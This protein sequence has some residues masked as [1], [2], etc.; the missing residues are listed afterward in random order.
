MFKCFNPCRAQFNYFSLQRKGYICIILIF[1]LHRL[2]LEHIL[3]STPINSLFNVKSTFI[4]SGGGCPEI[5]DKSSKLTSNWIH[6]G[7]QPVSQLH[8]LHIA[9]LLYWFLFPP[10]SVGCPVKYSPHPAAQRV[11]SELS[12]INHI[13]EAVTRV[14]PGHYKT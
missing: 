12:S 2:V 14:T 4:V 9:A 10:D 5:C 6:Q 1:A 13:T 7:S 11:L 8:Q 3:V